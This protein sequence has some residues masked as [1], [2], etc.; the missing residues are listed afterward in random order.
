MV[1]TVTQLRAD[2]DLVVIHKGHSQHVWLGVLLCVVLYSS[3]KPVTTLVFLRFQRKRRTTKALTCRNWV[4]KITQCHVFNLG[5]YVSRTTTV[6][7]CLVN[8]SNNKN[9][10]L[11]KL[12]II[13]IVSYSL[14][15]FLHV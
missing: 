5:A 4:S 11:I 14:Y 8:F 12:F 13:R 7:D 1:G 9:F 15:F 10:L 2:N 3:C 6:R